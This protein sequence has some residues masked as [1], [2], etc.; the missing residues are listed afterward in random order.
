MQLSLLHQSTAKRRE[1]ILRGPITPTLLLLSVPTI[2]MGIVQSAIPVIDGLYINNFSGTVAASAVTYCGPIVMMMSA[3]AQGLSV[4]GMAIIGQ[5][6]GKGEISAAKHVATQIVVSTF[7]IGLLMMPFLAILSFPISRHVTPSISH[8]VF[9]YLSLN[10]LVLPF[11]FLEFVYNAIKNSN[12]KPEAPFIRMVLMLGLKL[13]FNA[14]FIAVIPLGIVGTVISSLLAN[15]LICVW[16]YFEMF[17][18]KGDDK[19]E[20]RGF[21][22]DFEV[23]CELFKIGVPS[24]LSSVMLNLGFFLI[25]NEVEKYGPVTLNGQGIAN[26]ITSICFIVPSSFGSSVTTMVSMNVGAEQ[27][28][29]ARRSCIA[30]CIVSAISAVLLI[31]LVVPLSPHIT[32]LFTRNPDVLHI[33]NKALHIYT[34]SVVG[35][36]ICMVQLGAFIGL[37]RTSIPLVIGVLR[38]WLLRYMFILATEQFLGV[39]SVF[40]GNLFSN[41]MCAV[42]TTVLFLKIHWVS[43]IKTDTKDKAAAAV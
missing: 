19:L 30:G 16:M 1:M 27:G 2:M 7:L 43:V 25:N 23:I 34:Y 8:D 31:A 39:Y 36:G 38:I 12:G 3:L 14:I 5:M 29:K 11:S 28:N 26:N 20:L 35:F 37:G 21:R 32:V 6:N 41:Y 33:A 15:M 13:L 42:I 22:F 17:V 9:L 10:S 40:W 18:L 4:A 24:M